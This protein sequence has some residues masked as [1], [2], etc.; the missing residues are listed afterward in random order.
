[1]GL[2]ADLLPRQ[3][4]LSNILN[5]TPAACLFVGLTKLR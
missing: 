3:E 1:M 4:Q 5:Y 2:G